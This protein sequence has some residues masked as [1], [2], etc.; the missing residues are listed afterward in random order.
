MIVDKDFF[1]D[2]VNN[3]LIN[4]SSKKEDKM[5]ELTSQM[6]LEVH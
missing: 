3:Q 2:H 4:R 5:P 1:I 6:I